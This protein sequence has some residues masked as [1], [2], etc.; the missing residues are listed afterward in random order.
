MTNR[1]HIPFDPLFEESMSRL[2]KQYRIRFFKK[3]NG[4]KPGWSIPIEY[5]E[6]I[7]KLLHDVG[8]KVEQAPAKDEGTPKKKSDQE[9]QAIVTYKDQAIQCDVDLIPTER[10][11]KNDIA[12]EVKDFFK[13]FLQT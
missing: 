5:K 9:T 4:N 12:D 13:T 1:F 10:R 6:Q 2:K 3:L 11:Y 7:N 8:S